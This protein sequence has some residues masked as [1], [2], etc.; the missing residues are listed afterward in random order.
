MTLSSAGNS[1]S[2]IRAMS[3]FSE[4]AKYNDLTLGIDFY[5]VVAAY[6]EHFEEKKAGL[7]A[8]LKELCRRVFTKEA[9]MAA[10]ICDAQGFAPVPAAMEGFRKKLPQAEGSLA[11]ARI[12]C[13]K[14]N[15]G[16]MD[17]S[18]VQYVSRAGNFKQAGYRYTGALK[19]LKV[20][21]SY[22]YLWQNVRV[23]GGAYGC[24]GGFMRNGNAY[25]SSYRD[26]NL[27]KTNEVYEQI[28]AYL[29]HFTADERDMTKYI[30]G[31]ISEMD[32]PL[33]PAAK[34]M[35]SVTAYFMGVTDEDLQKERNE[36]IDATEESIRNLSGLAASV[37]GQDHL[38]VIG[39]EEM[40]TKEEELFQQTEQLF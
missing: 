19:I 7:I 26:P 35:R 13:T 12:T 36:V 39:N 2:A 21:L 25:F 1:V 32:T 3:Y 11:P 6:E 37:I 5:R 38:C 4:T 27:R 20:I 17:A 8:K 24:G 22:D 28:P 9:F 16:F 40:I 31:T 33:N 34:G 10:V 18:K 30:I 14:K 29:Q 23:K 15:E